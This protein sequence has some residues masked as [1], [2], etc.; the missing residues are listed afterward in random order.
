[1]NKNLKGRK[2]YLAIASLITLIGFGSCAN[3]IDIFT[4]YKEQA[5]I[6]GLID[7]SEPVQY[8]KVGRTFLNPNATAA[9]IAQISDSL[10]FKDVVVK[11]IEENNG[12]EI[13]LS[14]VDSIPKDSGYFQN[15]E[16]ILYATA[17]SINPSASYRL[18]VQNPITGYAASAKTLIVGVP[19]VSFPVSLNNR[20]WSVAPELSIQLRFNS[21]INAKQQDAYFEFWV[22]EF[23]VLTPS[24]KEL[25]HLRWRFVRNLK[26]E[27]TSPG[28]KVNVSPGA[29]FYDFFLANL[30]NGIFKSDSN[31]VRRIVKTD[32]VLYS[33]SQ[34]LVDYVEASTPGIGIVQKQTEYSN[35]ENGIGLFSSR[36][37][38]R[39]P[40]VIIDS[41]S[42]AFFN[43]NRYPQYNKVRMVP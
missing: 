35:I 29:G 42:I 30:E 23:D 37:T 28:S 40:N 38:L 22:E 25:K 34:D 43:S 8:I 15:K 12:R 10:Y 18:F 2:Y 24:I 36:S 5:V 26:N 4:E 13:I 33:A 20:Y 41:V 9:Q 19:F 32:F 21:G 1:M 16:N 31:Y 7:L 27:T 39:I 17:E 3:D 6:Y 11:L 14:R